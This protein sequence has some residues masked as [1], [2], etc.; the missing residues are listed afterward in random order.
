MPKEGIYTD[1][2]GTFRSKD[3]I[4]Y[5]SF[6]KKPPKYSEKPYEDI[7]FEEMVD[8]AIA[9]RDSKLKFE[10]LPDSVEVEIESTTPIVLGCFGDQ[11]GMAMYCDY[12]LL[13]EHTNAIASNPKFYSII[14]GDLVDGAAFNPAQDSKIGSFAEESLFAKKML[15]KIGG[16]SIIAML[17]GDHDMWAERGGPTA[18]QD[19]KERYNTPILRGSSTITVKV[20]EISYVIVA[21]HK[22]P[23]SSIYN[24]THPENRE[25]KFGQQG[26]D[27]Y[28]GFHCFDDKTEILTPNGWVN[29]LEIEAGDVVGTMNKETGEF[30]WNEVNGKVEYDNYKE[31]YQLETKLVSICTTDQHGMLYSSRT[32]EGSEK[33]KECTMEE[34]SQK[35]SAKLPVTIQS[36]LVNKK[37]LLLQRWLIWVVTD[38]SIRRSRNVISFHLKKDRKIDRLTQL[39]ND[40]GYQYR[41]AEGTDGSTF[42]YIYDMKDLVNKYFPSRKVLGRWIFNFDPETV[43]E[44]YSHT[45]GNKCE[46]RSIQLSSAKRE[47]IDLLQEYFAI[48]GYRSVANFNPKR[49]ASTL[50]VSPRKYAVVYP[51]RDTKKVKYDGKV[52]CVYVDNGTLIV[53]RNGKVVITQNTHQKAIAQQVARQANGEDLM[54][55][56]VSSGPYKYSSKYAQKQ[57]FGQQRE[58]SLGAVWLVLHPYRKEV[59]AFWSLK[60]AEERIKPYLTGK[61]K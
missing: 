35:R 24:K 8:E 44:E 27:I 14:G 13:R 60:S 19:F 56:Y 4:I 33:I 58:K 6:E 7:T 10:G 43:I 11:H 16:D 1:S 41:I 26:A 25:S 38:G 53:R 59:E 34:L 22:L 48:S 39:L 30:D 32:E 42:F 2:K 61:L 29:G 31:L 46:G 20:G 18:Y 5:D 52:W 36:R 15:D 12:E 45:D 37:N 49:A 57:G 21:A 40:I 55:T 47:E 23:G 54:Q 28:M 50:H 51:K 9:R 17:E 3:Q